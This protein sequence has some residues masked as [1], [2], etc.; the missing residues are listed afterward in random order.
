MFI[1]GW[2]LDQISKPIFYES[3]RCVYSVETVAVNA[4]SKH[5]AVKPTQTTKSDGNSQPP[6]HE[7]ASAHIGHECVRQN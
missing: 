7:E 1:R 4:A 6:N 2:F 5:T 3:S